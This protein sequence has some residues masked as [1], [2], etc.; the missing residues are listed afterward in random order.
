MEVVGHWFDACTH[1]V[2]YI[3][4]LFLNKKFVTLLYKSFIFVPFV[5][6]PRPLDFTLLWT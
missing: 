1:K 3:K 6:K 2:Q 4:R 5:L